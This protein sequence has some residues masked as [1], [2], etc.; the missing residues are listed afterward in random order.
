MPSDPESRSM[1]NNIDDMV[2]IVLAKLPE[3][4]FK[5]TDRRYLACETHIKWA[6]K[7]W[8][9]FERVAIHTKE[10]GEI[11]RISLRAEEEQR[12]DYITREEFYSAL[13]Q[14]SLPLESPPD[15]GTSET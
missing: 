11:T 12:R 13:G 7:G 9:K 3:F 14:I 5:W 1:V 15:E 6:A 4:V 8:P 10:D 2:A